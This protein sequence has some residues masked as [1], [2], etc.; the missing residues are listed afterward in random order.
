MNQLAAAATTLIGVCVAMATS[1]TTPDPM[2]RTGLEQSTCLNGV[3]EDFEQCDDGN[4]VDGDTC[5]TNCQLIRCGDAAKSHAEECDDG[6]VNATDGCGGPFCE[7]TPGWLCEPSQPSVPGSTSLCQLATSGLVINEIDYDNVGTDNLEYIELRNNGATA[8]PLAGLAVVL[9][10]GAVL[11]A[12]EYARHDLAQARDSAGNLAT[13]IGPGRYLVIANSTLLATL[14]AN[15]LRL[16]ITTPADNIIQNGSRDAVGLINTNTNTLLDAM[17]YE[18]AVTSANITGL[19]TISLAEGIEFPL[20]AADSNNLDGALGRIPNGRDMNDHAADWRF[21]LRKTPGSANSPPVQSIANI[22]PDNAVYNLGTGTIRI[23]GT[24]L[25]PGIIVRLAG[26]P[27]STCA[28]ENGTALSCLIPA[29][30][31]L[32]ER[33]DVVLTNPHG[34]VST[35]AQAFRYTGNYNDPGA[36]SSAANICTLLGPSVLESTVGVPT[37]ASFV[38]FYEPGVTEPAGA[39]TGWIAEIGF[40]P[41]GSDPR[42]S[43]D[44]RYAPIPWFSQLDLGDQFAGSLLGSQS[45]TFAFTFRVSGDGGIHYTYCDRDGAGVSIGFS[46]AQL[47]SW[48]VNPPP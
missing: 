4:A 9:A 1:A 10:N 38:D 48:T 26:T 6:S 21:V 8:L 46:P 19:G 41:V 47:G 33:G 17:S 11:P 23:L 3:V 14:P 30:S 32:P 34:V 29:H 36:P 27:T 5:P 31:G 45:G 2:F 43:N 7:V 28:T 35:L 25:M 24:D 44:W 37:E 39:P 12:T 15:A 42:V 22:E 40:G 20:A 16:L 13:H 18:G